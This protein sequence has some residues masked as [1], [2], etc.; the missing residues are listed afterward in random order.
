VRWPARRAAAS[1]ARAA[2]SP[3]REHCNRGY[4]TPTRAG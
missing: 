3:R 1:P 4:T 2:G